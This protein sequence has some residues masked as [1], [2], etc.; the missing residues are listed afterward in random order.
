MTNANKP[1]T[2]SMVKLDKP[3]QDQNTANNLQK[4]P[5]EEQA[6]LQP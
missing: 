3:Q 2:V 1:Q 6:A 5:G 4:I